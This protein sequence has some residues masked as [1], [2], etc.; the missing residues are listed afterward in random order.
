MT[1]ICHCREVPDEKPTSQTESATQTPQGSGY[2]FTDL[3]VDVFSA[4]T[5]GV[6]KSLVDAA[7][8]ESKK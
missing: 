1:K 3:C 4:A 8:K 6:P 7:V 2:G 5:I